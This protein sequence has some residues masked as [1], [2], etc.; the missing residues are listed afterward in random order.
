MTKLG[1]FLAALLL[2]LV[3]SA[4]ASLEPATGDPALAKSAPDIRALL[5]ADSLAHPENKPKN[6]AI[7]ATLDLAVGSKSDVAAE[8]ARI[9]A[10]VAA[11]Q[12]GTPWGAV[13]GGASGLLAAYVA[14]RKARADAAAA[15]GTVAAVVNQH[16]VVI[17]A[18]T[19]DTAE[20]AAKLPGPVAAHPVA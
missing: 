4:C 13:A 15:V 20:W 9:A 11:S 7:L 3:L 5:I 18:D 16:A 14:W 19:P 8:A 17:D 6:D 1:S 12:P 2:A 10:L